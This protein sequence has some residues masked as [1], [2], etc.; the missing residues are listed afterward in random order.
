MDRLYDGYS[1]GF[2]HIPDEKVTK[3]F[4]KLA[5]IINYGCLNYFIYLPAF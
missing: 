5:D 2:V 3:Y 4:E 1:F